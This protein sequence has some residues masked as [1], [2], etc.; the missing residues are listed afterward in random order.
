M[1]KGKK[2]LNSKAANREEAVSKVNE[3]RSIE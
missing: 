1:K 2:E 3:M